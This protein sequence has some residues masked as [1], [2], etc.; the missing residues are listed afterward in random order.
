MGVQCWLTWLIS[1]HW[2]EP[3][4]PSNANDPDG[5]RFVHVISVYQLQGHNLQHFTQIIS[6]TPVCIHYSSIKTR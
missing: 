4:A 6:S 1:D 5:T 3:P 2:E